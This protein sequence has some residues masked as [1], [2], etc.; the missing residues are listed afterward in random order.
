MKMQAV[1]FNNHNQPEFFSALRKRVNSYFKENNISKYANRSMK[2]KTAF[3]LAL[4]FVPLLVLVTGL[5]SSF[6]SMMVMWVLMGFGMSGIGTSIMHDANHGSY[7][8]KAWVN[9]ALGY[10][11]NLIGGYHVNWKIQHNVLHHSY[12][13]VHGHDEDITNAVMRFSP[14]QAHKK[15]Y[16]FQ[17]YYAPFFYSIMTLYWLVS[18]DF[19]QLV[20]YKKNSLLDKQGV[21][22]GGGLTH[23][24][25]NKVG[26]LVI[27]LVV[28]MLVLS[29]AW[30]QVLI[31]FVV[32]HLIC[33]LL[34]A[35][36]FQPAHVLEETEFMMP[37]EAGSLENHWAIH[38][39]RTT[40]NFAHRSRIFS[41]FIGGLNY[42]IEHHLFPNIC[43]VHYKKISRIVK[44]TAEEYG[45]PYYQHKTFVHAL[46]SHFRLLND[47]GTGRYDR[48]LATAGA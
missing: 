11:V 44:E 47:L 16:R 30:W 35:L 2:V 4:Y 1:R 46:A 48:K 38:Q 34:L 23:V 25:L 9:N 5:V 13:N 17:L 43:H 7:S 15:M 20:R 37:D 28:P 12:T 29:V 27:T 36:I 14:D 32:M 10:M 24:I 22:F 18:K 6:W 19:E 42:Q 40:S 45:I 41:W 3:M 33:G 26:Y 39:M 21:S 31:G 8:K